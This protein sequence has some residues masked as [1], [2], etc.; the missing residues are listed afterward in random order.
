[1]ACAP[2]CVGHGTQLV[3]LALAGRPGHPPA[4][5]CGLVFLLSNRDPGGW[6]GPPFIIIII[7]IRH[8]GISIFDSATRLKVH[9]SAQTPSTSLCLMSNLC[10]DPVPTTSPVAPVNNNSGLC[11][12]AVFDQSLTRL[13]AGLL[14]HIHPCILSLCPYCFML[15]LFASV[16]QGSH[17]H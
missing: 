6:R 4:W 2:V 5:C 11:T 8:H 13:P 1:M 10:P 14:A 7:I 12:A 3:G 17:Y 9:C 16:N 15:C